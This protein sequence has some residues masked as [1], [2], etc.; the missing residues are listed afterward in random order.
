MTSETKDREPGGTEPATQELYNEG[1]SS[2]EELDRDQLMRMGKV[3]VLKVS[4]TTA[5]CMASTN[6]Q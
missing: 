4:A 6:T 1:L 2:Q 3:P 5:L